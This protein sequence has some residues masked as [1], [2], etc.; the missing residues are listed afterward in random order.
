M[1][2]A[3]SGTRARKAPRRGT[4]AHRQAALLRLAVDLVAA[5]DEAQVCQRLVDGL[6][7]EALGYDFLG[8]FLLDDSR[9]RS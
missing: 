4:V 3:S 8:A 9:G 5:T 6:H 7:D 2:Q 1:R